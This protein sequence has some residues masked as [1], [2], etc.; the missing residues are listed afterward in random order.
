MLMQ[1]LQKRLCTL[2]HKTGVSEL[3]Q[4]VCAHRRRVSV[5]NP[6][7]IE[8]K[9]EPAVFQCFPVDGA[10]LQFLPQLVVDPLIEIDVIFK[11]V[12]LTPGVVDKGFVGIKNQDFIFAQDVIPGWPL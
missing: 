10:L 8:N 9:F 5:Y 2:Y 1:A 11:G 7:F 3:D 4:V 12:C 6:E